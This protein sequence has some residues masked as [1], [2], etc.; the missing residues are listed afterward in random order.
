MSG[1]SCS[2]DSFLSDCFVELVS[3]NTQL[4]GEVE[5]LTLQCETL[6]AEK[7]QSNKEKDQCNR[8][9]EGRWLSWLYVIRKAV[10][11]CSCCRPGNSN[12][13]VDH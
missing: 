5:Q 1:I 7:D 13:T 2:I 8:Q 12:S 9:K 3:Q 11:C 10:M 4:A 6:R